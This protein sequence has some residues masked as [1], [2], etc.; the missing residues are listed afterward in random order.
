MAA[1]AEYNTIALDALANLAAVRTQ[2]GNYDAALELAPHI[3]QHPAGTQE[4]KDQARRMHADLTS[5]F[6]PH[7]VMAIEARA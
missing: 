4:T 3:V 7:Q 2:Q 6:G 1:D 5:H